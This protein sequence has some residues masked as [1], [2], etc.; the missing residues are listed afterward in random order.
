MRVFSSS[1][2]KVALIVGMASAAAVP[3]TG[4]AAGL[5]GMIELSVS[6]D[7]GQ[8]FSGDCYLF[9]KS[10][11]EKRHRIQGQVPTKFWLPAIAVRCHLQKNNAN[12]KMVLTVKHDGKFEFSQPSRFPFKWVFVASRGPWGQAQGHYSASGLFPR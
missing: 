1:L 7:P 12:G 3:H 2:I 11:K 9:Q 10:G 4:S 5:D 6:G 8:K